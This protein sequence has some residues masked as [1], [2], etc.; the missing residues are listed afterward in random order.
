MFVSVERSAYLFIG[1]ALIEAV[2]NATERAARCCHLSQCLFRSW[3][4]ATCWRPSCIHNSVKYISYATLP[5][6]KNVGYLTI[7]EFLEKEETKPYLKIICILFPFGGSSV[8]SYVVCWILRN[9]V[10]GFIKIQGY[11]KWLSGF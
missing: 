5:N 2:L 1:S 3:E 4:E 6:A 7:R 11:S 8:S 10:Q 9:S